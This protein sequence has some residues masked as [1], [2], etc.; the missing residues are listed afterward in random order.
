MFYQ[1]VGIGESL[2]V[3]PCLGQKKKNKQSYIP[4]WGQHPQFYHLKTKDKKI[5]FLA[6]EMEQTLPHSS[7]CFCILEVKQNLIKQFRTFVHS[8]AIPCLLLPHVKDWPTQNYIPC[9]G[10]RTKPYPVQ[11]HI[12]PWRL[13][14]GVQPPTP[15]PPSPPPGKKRLQLVSI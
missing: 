15:T 1:Y 9:L 10:Y 3:F 14:E 6:I 11:W 7:H 5:V 8:Q 2:R 4:R 12:T 13:W